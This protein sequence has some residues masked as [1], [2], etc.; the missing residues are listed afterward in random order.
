MGGKAFKHWDSIPE[1]PARI[2]VDILT[3]LHS[4]Y[5]HIYIYPPNNSHVTNPVSTAVF[6]YV[7]D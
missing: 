1:R 5:I 7:V 3:E 6:R 2:P 4:Q